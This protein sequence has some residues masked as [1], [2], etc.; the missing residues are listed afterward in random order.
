MVDKKSPQE[1]LLAEESAMRKGLAEWEDNEK[2]FRDYM[3]TFVREFDTFIDASK[4]KISAK[5]YALLQHYLAPYRHLTVNPFFAMSKNAEGKIDIAKSLQAIQDTM[6][7][8]K[9]MDKN[10]KLYTECS[11]N[12]MGFQDLLDRLGKEKK[13][14]GEFS[15]L[16][17]KLRT[18]ATQGEGEMNAASFAIKPIQRTAHY[19][20]T[21][22]AIIKD[23][24][25]LA[26]SNPQIAAI[27]HSD[28]L[29]KIKG[30]TL[31][32][33]QALIKI[34]TQDNLQ[35][36]IDTTANLWLTTTIRRNNALARAT[37]QNDALGMAQNNPLVIASFFATPRAALESSRKSLQSSDSKKIDKKDKK[38]IEALDRHLA[39]LKMLEDK[40]NN[41]ITPSA[42][43]DLIKTLENVNKDLKK[44]S[45]GKKN[46]PEKERLLQ[47][48]A[49]TLATVK[50]F[51]SESTLHDLQFADIVKK[52][53]PTKTFAAPTALTLPPAARAATT[54]ATSL[55][56]PVMR[57]PPERRP[58]TPPKRPIAQSQP[59]VTTTPRVATKKQPGR[60]MFDTLERTLEQPKSL[61]LRDEKGV[62]IGPKSQTPPE[63]I[64][65]PPRPIRRPA[66]KKEDAEG[67]GKGKIQPGKH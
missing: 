41:N 11:A 30:K 31:A 36:A 29:E 20:L 61:Q 24:P 9:E 55:P 17:K 25:R 19:P 10:F 4:G 51:D 39:T 34:S 33:N 63:K 62:P 12:I 44:R 35:R 26:E 37:K 23:K 67:E 57:K 1:S 3:V 18:N 58:P 7:N 28:S 50:K 56:R 47:Q 8:S 16:H 13:L 46:K 14:S 27:I 38:F 5:D 21:F 15:D 53:P 64:V 32:T 49:L 54:V 60:N 42:R 66:E 43:A 6:L 48:L 40:H 2:R 65:V 52:R 45:I 22:E 59:Q